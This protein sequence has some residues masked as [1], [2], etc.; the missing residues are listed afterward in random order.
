M[1][2]VL[3]FD[4]SGLPTWPRSVARPRTSRFWHDMGCRVPPGFCLTTD[5]FREFVRDVVFP[6]LHQGLKCGGLESADHF[7]HEIRPILGQ[8]IR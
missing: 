4:R 5:A 1:S 6:K 7:C 8:R 3:A 2:L